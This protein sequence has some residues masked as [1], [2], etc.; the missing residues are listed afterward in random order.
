MLGGIT[1]TAMNMQKLF[2]AL[3]LVSLFAT[4]MALTLHLT[5]SSRV[6]EDWKTLL[7]WDG[8]AGLVDRVPD[9]LPSSWGA[10]ILLIAGFLVAIAFVVLTLLTQ[11][12]MMLFWRFARPGFL[13]TTALSLVLSPFLGLS[14]TLPL[15]GAMY[16]LATLCDGA[17]LAMA[18]FSPLS[19]RFYGVRATS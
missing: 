1:R 16:Y 15:E 6:S 9:T 4:V 18:Y 13:I 2:R 14:V 10:R 12:G 19:E 3:L 17:V 8:D 11:I 5:A 7:Q